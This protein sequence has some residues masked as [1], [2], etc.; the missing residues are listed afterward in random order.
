MTLFPM[1]ECQSCGFKTTSTSTIDFCPKCGDAD[2]LQPKHFL[3][4]SKDDDR[5]TPQATNVSNEAKEK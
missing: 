1:R 2:G 3:T 4:R 5:R